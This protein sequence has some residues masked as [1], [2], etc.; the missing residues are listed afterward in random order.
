MT[1]PFSGLTRRARIKLPLTRT[2]GP[3]PNHHHPL[4]LKYTAGSTSKERPV[5]PSSSEM[6]YPGR[7]HSP[8]SL[9]SIIHSSS[10]C[11]KNPKCSEREKG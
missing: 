9:P 2:P 6:M 4:L 10:G 11:N 3:D 5:V 8:S 7:D 1:S